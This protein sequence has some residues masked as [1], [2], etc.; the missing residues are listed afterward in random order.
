MLVTMT[1]AISSPSR[2]MGTAVFSLI[3]RIEAIT[4]PVQA[5]VPG[6]GT[7]TKSRRPSASYFRTFSAFVSVFC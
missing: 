7:A 4:A 5:P 3:S 1:P 2:I 6:R